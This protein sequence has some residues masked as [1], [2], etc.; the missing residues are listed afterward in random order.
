MKL[1]AIFTFT[2]ACVFSS[3]LSLPIPVAYGIIDV[4]A[5][6]SSVKLRYGP[7]AD[8]STV[9]PYSEKVLQAILD[10]AGLDSAL[11][12]STTRTPEDQARIMFDNLESQGVKAQLKLYGAAGDRVIKVYEASKLAGKSPDEIKDDMLDAINRLGPS[13]VSH[14]VADPKVSNVIDIAP[15]SISDKKAFLQALREAE[16]QGLISKPFGPPK[17]PAYH[18][19]IAQP[20]DDPCKKPTGDL[21]GTLEVTF[22]S[23]QTTHTSN[24]D[25][26]LTR[27]DIVSTPVKAESSGGVLTS[28]H[29]N[30]P[31][32]ASK[33]VFGGTAYGP[34]G[35][36]PPVTGYA[37]VDLQHHTVLPFLSGEVTVSNGPGTTNTCGLGAP[38][39]NGFPDKLTS[40]GD[41]V[42][43]GSLPLGD[44]T[45]LV[46]QY[47][48]DVELHPV[49]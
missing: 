33:C 5:D 41:Y 35:P 2:I 26:T 44:G 34:S 48:W 32:P 6:N 4:C 36:P 9:S 21:E 28:I 11:V 12:T 42:S 13:N 8:S 30:G 29:F 45:I 25:V 15:S 23:T 19:E 40:N 17:D 47:T 3:V 38:P 49:P 31:S 20:K 24:G 37:I 39:P 7:N 46:Q 18:I 10:E 27:D 1:I 16:K 14:H 22:K 43:K